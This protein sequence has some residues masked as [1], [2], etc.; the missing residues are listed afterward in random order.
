LSVFAEW[1]MHFYVQLFK[2]FRITGSSGSVHGICQKRLNSLCT[3][4]IWTLFFKHEHFCSLWPIFNKLC[5]AWWQGTSIFYYHTWNM[6]PLEH[7]Q[8][9]CISV[10]CSPYH[11]NVQLYWDFLG[12]KLTLHILTTLCIHS[13]TILANLLQK[14]V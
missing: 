10:I 1:P 3:L 7:L 14:N 11:G 5:A 8:K 9:N 4:L 2:A 13:N 12:V 6:L